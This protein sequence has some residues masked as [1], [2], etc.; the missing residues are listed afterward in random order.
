MQ[1]TMTNL[2]TAFQLSH[3]TAFLGQLSQKH[4]VFTIVS[5]HTFKHLVLHRLLYCQTLG[6][7]RHFATCHIN[8]HIHICKKKKKQMRIN[9][10]RIFIFDQCQFITFFFFT[11][12][13]SQKFNAYSH[14]HSGSF[15][16]QNH[17][18]REFSLPSLHMVFPQQ[19][20]QEVKYEFYIGCFP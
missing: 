15:M 9:K 13:Q 14:C 18:V 10:R 7:S 16:S 20:F 12:C 3:L 4:M 8:T 11:Q 6:T 5:A 2:K 17:M 19:F 1:K